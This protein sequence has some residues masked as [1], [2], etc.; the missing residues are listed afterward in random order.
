LAG[1]AV[2]RFHEELNREQYDAI[3]REAE[4][5]FCGDGKR[6]DT[7]KFLQAVRRKLG[8]AGTES[9]VNLNVN[10]SLEGVTITTQYKT[11]FARG[12]ANETFTWL[13]KNG[14]LKLY[15]YNIQANALV[16][17]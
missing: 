15:G 7:V 10:T 17:N 11:T 9:L 5:E 1:A 8:D 4:E 16:M 2:G 12:M 14:K 13:R 3:C 6:D